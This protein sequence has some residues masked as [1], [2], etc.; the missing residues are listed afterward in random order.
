MTE[1]FLHYLWQNQ[2]FTS[3]LLTSDKDPITIL[4]TGYH[5]FNAGPDF[6]DAK[7]TIGQTLWA[8][9]VEIH[10]NASDWFKHGHQFDAA[11]D[12]VI[13]HVV[14]NNDLKEVQSKMP[15]CELKNHIDEN[16]YDAYL[17]FIST[18]SF[19]ACEKKIKHVPETDLSLWLERMLV[20]RIEHKSDL[21]KNSLINSNNDWEEA[22]YQTIGRSF[23]FSINGLPF[24]LLTRSLPLRI[25]ARCANNAFQVEALLFGQAGLLTHD[26]T[27]VFGQALFAE[28][29]FLRKKYQLVPIAASLW[30]FLRLRPVN[31]PTIRISQFASLL[32]N[33]A[34]FLS[35][36]ISMTNVN[37]M[38]S[39]FKIQASG[40]WD[41]H[42]TFDQKSSIVRTKVLGE[43]SANLII[44]NAI[45]PFMFFYGRSLGN[46]E[47]CNKALNFFDRI[48]GER[49]TV[50]AR[51]KEI[52]M[53]TK[54]AYKTQSLLHLKNIYCAPRRCLECRI[55]N[56]IFK[57]PAFI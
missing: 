37:E 11:Y 2:L 34:G 14:Y 5:N 38:V 25:I 6:S 21:I 40:Y 23:G 39:M 27:D 52:G 50:I 9:N 24:E 32:S 8:G 56:L 36:L 28:Y 46:D 10:V 17:D 26:L 29:S 53:E 3:Q 47:L 45:L 57:D 19:I 13:L 4:R 41:D 30:K 31:F 22:L 15:V 20:E 51:W 16:L 18:N 12:N 42:Y 44:I 35:K 33:N 7:L 55:G 54:S 43:A 1:D 48:N 49:N